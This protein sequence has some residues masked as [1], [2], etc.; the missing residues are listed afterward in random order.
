M[1]MPGYNKMGKV[2]PVEVYVFVCHKRQILIKGFHSMLVLYSMPPNIHIIWKLQE[3]IN[4]KEV[5]E[6]V[7]N[8]KELTY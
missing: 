7:N 3:N 1:I 8:K 6:G 4:E 5:Y 2:F